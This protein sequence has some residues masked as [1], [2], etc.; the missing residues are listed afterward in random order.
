MQPNLPHDPEAEWAILALILTDPTRIREVAGVSPDAFY[1]PVNRNIF[2]AMKKLFRYGHSI[3]LPLLQDVLSEM[4]VWNSEVENMLLNMSVRYTLAD[5]PS[6]FEGYRDKLLSAYHKRL[7]IRLAEEITEAANR[8]L[9]DSQRVVEIAKKKVRTLEESVALVQTE[10]LGPE[11]L[12]EVLQA[13]RNRIRANTFLSEMI[14]GFE[15]TELVLVAARPAVGKTAFLL[16]EAYDIAAEFPVLFVSREMSEWELMQRLRRYTAGRI[17]EELPHRQFFVTTSARTPAEVELAARRVG[18]KF[19]FVDY[20]QRLSPGHKVFTREQEIGDISHALKDMAMDLG[21]VVIA[22]AQLNRDSERRENREPY[23]A[24]LRD[25]GRLEQDANQV[26]MLWR[27]PLEEEEPFSVYWK[28]AKNR[29]GPERRGKLDFVPS[30][31]RF[32]KVG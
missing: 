24:D 2:Q 10:V 19:V 22:A 31:M 3:S 11:D 30:E 13:Q 17:H 27:D 28:V 1:E 29:R 12:I 7:A 14:D 9:V 5:V 8:P 32:Y 25:S 23:L 15:E 26:I 6:L 21:V 18:A 16:T 20:I 4:G